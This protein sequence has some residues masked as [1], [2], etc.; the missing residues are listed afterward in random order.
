MKN[1]N[2]TILFEYSP[3]ICSFGSVVGK[4]ESQGPF[5]D[6]YDKIVY[7]SYFGQDTFENAESEMLKTAVEIALKKVS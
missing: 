2:G 3:S 7:D 4:K 5:R 6:E 1:N